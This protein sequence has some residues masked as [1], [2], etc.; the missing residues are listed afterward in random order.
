VP[1]YE[2]V[3]ESCGRLTEVMQKVG[4]PPPATCGEC[5]GTRLA[6]LVSRTSFHLKGGGWYADLY[7][8][9]GKEKGKGKAGEGTPAGSAA[10]AKKDAPTATPGSGGTGSGSTGS[11][12]TGSGGTGSGSTGSGGTGGTGTSGTGG[13]KG[14]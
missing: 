1:I 9:A 14:G 5:G 12:S 11:G 8:S 10:P 13:A 2:Y 3:C 7:S 6:K 4:D